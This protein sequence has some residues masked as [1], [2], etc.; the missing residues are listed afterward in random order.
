MDFRVLEMASR[1]LGEG[2]I[3]DHCMGRIFA[4][5]STGL[6]NDV[7]GAAVKLVLSMEGDRLRQD[8][9]GVGLLEELSVSSVHARSVLGMD[10]DKD[11]RCWVCG[12]LFE[13]VGVWVERVIETLSSVECDSFL[14]GTRVTGLLSENEEIL[15]AESGTRFAEP[16]KSELNRE[17]GKR[18]EARTGKRVDFEH[19]D[20]LLLLDL[21][22]DVVRREI[23]P[24]FISGRYRKLVRG[25]PQ[26]RWPC[27]EC[28][29]QGCERCGFTGKLYPESVDELIARPVLDAFGGE[30]TVFHGA[31]REDIDALMLGSG[32]PF[33]IEVK[34]AKKRSADISRLAESVN[35]FAREKVEVLGL[36]YTDGSEVERIKGVRADKVYKL[37]VSFDG[38]VSEERLKSSLG[39]ITGEIHQQTPNR[40]LH[41]RA[42]RVRMRRVFS[43][44]VEGFDSDRA[45]LVVRCEGGLYVKEL[46]SGDAGRTS[47]SLSE[48]LGTGAEVVELDV[49][50]VKL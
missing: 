24:L 2:A 38:K 17:V 11:G 19:P 13:T 39:L 10:R 12:D 37:S 15:W 28:G 21:G 40:V 20:V 35:E 4:R 7:R 6:S 44:E 31:G 29:G 8:S 45:V 30:D 33:V 41:R 16:I 34:N 18:V 1:V 49:I 25:I 26:T 42:D 46:V 32:R 50:D 27:R 5:L 43:I 14:V 3:C 9:D 36:Q 48:V 22:E 47:P 23:R